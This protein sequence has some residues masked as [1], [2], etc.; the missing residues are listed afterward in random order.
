MKV[1]T[2]V[3]IRAQTGLDCAGEL[4]KVAFGPRRVG[5]RTFWCLQELTPVHD[6]TVCRQ[7][8]QL[9]WWPEG[10]LEEAEAPSWGAWYVQSASHV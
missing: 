4:R 6:M 5:G 2:W 10:Y 7:V 9:R 3:R 1:G 8:G